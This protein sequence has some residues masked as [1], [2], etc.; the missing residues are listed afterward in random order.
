LAFVDCRFIK[1]VGVKADNGGNNLV[2]EP[3]YLLHVPLKGCFV[4]GL[5][6]YGV[7]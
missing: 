3:L 1:Q 7:A 2:F 4:D 5:D 6:A